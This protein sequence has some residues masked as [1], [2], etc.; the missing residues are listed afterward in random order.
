MHDHI[1]MNRLYNHLLT[2]RHVVGGPSGT[3][4]PLR[5]AVQFADSRQVWPAR[6]L[7]SSSSDDIAVL[8]VDNIVGEV[9]TIL[10][11]NQ[12]IEARACVPGQLVMDVD[13]EGF[14][15]AVDR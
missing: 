15:E 9:P 14:L 10:G 6:V 5:L 11:F 8:K 2:S 13:E 12:R 1:L 4:T 7:A 3:Q